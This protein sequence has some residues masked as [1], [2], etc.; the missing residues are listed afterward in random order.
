MGAMCVRRAETAVLGCAYCVPVVTLLL[1][2][3]CSFAFIATTDARTSRVVEARSSGQASAVSK[4]A[5]GN[6]VRTKLAEGEYE[7]SARTR[8]GAVGPFDLQV[9]DFR[10]T[11]VLWRTE[12]GGYEVDGERRFESPK[13]RF[14]K[15]RFWLQ[16][17]RDWR[18]VTIKE[19]A[20]LRWRRDS[21]PLVCN[22][23]VAAVHCTS[24]AKDPSQLV[25]LDVNLDHPFGFLWPISPFSLSSI[26]KA[27]E[28]RVN[29]VMSVQLI[30]IE[31]PSPEE[32]VS[33]TLIDGRLR[34]LGKVDVTLAG[35]KW[36]GDQ[37]EL[38]AVLHPK[39]RIVT[40]EEGFLLDL[41]VE[42]PATG[43]PSAEM[44]L[45]RYQESAGLHSSAAQ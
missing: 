21:G 13:D 36:R 40:A 18:L 33:P 20:K 45:V 3:T 16:L 30:T 39:F 22:F 27:E 42:S 14:H 8:E 11:W 17:T 24:N 26:A 38:E 1:L 25:K 32:P 2:A 44:K 43:T 9:F 12:D 19:F 6:T 15:D 34:Y 37:F 35:R 29:E 31:E 28:R 23:E 5:S 41:V 4:P 10:E 7:V